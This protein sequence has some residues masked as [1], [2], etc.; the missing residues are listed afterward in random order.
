MANSAN[1]GGSDSYRRLPPSKGDVQHLDAN[2]VDMTH[3]DIRLQLT[4]ADIRLAP[5]PNKSLGSEQ[6][7]CTA[8][9]HCGPLS[10]R[11]RILR[12]GAVGYSAGRKAA[13]NRQI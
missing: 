6:A 5:M 7:D 13:V 3:V 12:K 10:G 8:C 9:L 4:R 11:L 2:Y 1:I